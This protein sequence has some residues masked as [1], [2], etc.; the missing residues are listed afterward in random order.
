MHATPVSRACLHTSLALLTLTCQ[1]SCHS[2]RSLQPPE[3]REVRLTT[4]AKAIGTNS[5]RKR[6][7]R[8]MLHDP[9]SLGLN[10]PGYLVALEKTQSRH[11]AA[12]P[13]AAAAASFDRHIHEKADATHQRL[14]AEA[15]ASAHADLR[16]LHDRDTIYREIAKATLAPHSR[17]F[18]SHIYKHESKEP[19]D[20][21]SK[22][23][24]Y[25]A[26]ETDVHGPERN[27]DIYAY[28]LNAMRE[29]E[30]NVAQDVRDRD[31][32]DIFVYSMGWNTDQ[33][34]ALENYNALFG[35]FLAQCEKDPQMKNIRPLF[36]GLSWDSGW[37]FRLGGGMNPF[38]FWTKKSD[39]DVI[40]GLWASIIVNH[41]ALG[42]KQQRPN[43]RVFLV[44]HS[45]GGRLLLTSLFTRDLLPPQD[46]P[47]KNVQVDAALLLQAAANVGRL[48]RKHDVLPIFDA[49]KTDT[50][51]VLTWSKNDSTVE[52]A[53]WTRNIGGAR[54]HARAELRDRPLPEKDKVFQHFVI[55]RTGTHLLKTD[56]DLPALEQSHRILY[57]D[58]TQVISSHSDI[59]TPEVATMLKYI[60]KSE[61]F[62]R[63]Q[64]KKTAR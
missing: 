14:E 62:P 39:A 7:Y 51:L 22:R 4:K 25:S 59:Y 28:S 61:A 36:I 3:S 40:G 38:S 6:S 12:R 56:P 31:I 24:I 19:F 35:N 20:R 11:I 1:V 42:I 37:K 52:I 16:I 26:Y 18:V 8:R 43:T 30:K 13:L 63:S 17:P 49:S 45:F 46:F 5:T 48:S 54:G 55:Q 41:I 27:G 23:A 15:K 21:I 53:R 29:L 2:S 58:A 47:S 44:G 57:G 10:F 9:D 60:V 34:G 32:T 50:R 64:G 33:Q